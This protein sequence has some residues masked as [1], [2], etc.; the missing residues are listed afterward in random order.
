MTISQILQAAT[1]KEMFWLFFFVFFPAIVPILLY[2]VIFRKIPW[3]NPIKDLKDFREIIKEIVTY[4][5][6]YE[7]G[8]GDDY[9][10]DE[11]EYDGSGA[12]SGPTIR[13]PKNR[14]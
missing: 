13:Y 12:Y 5:P 4:V 1:P 14:Q 3:G 2:I 11:H 9:Y 8:G 6:D 7:R 10:Y